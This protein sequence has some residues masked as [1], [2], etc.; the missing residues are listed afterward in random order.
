MGCREILKM[1]PE[2]LNHEKVFDVME[3]VTEQCKGKQLF[4]QG[5]KL[6]EAY[7]KMFSM[8]GDMIRKIDP[9]AGTGG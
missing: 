5:W 8:V 7:E 6:Y 1:R 2:C 9:S 4:G 3:Q